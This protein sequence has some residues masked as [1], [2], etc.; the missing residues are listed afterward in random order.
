MLDGNQKLLTAFL[1]TLSIFKEEVNLDINITQVEI[2]LC[3]LAGD[4]LS[5]KQITEKF[6]VRIPSASR[7]V[8]ALTDFK[9]PGVPGY[10]LIELR[11]DPKDFRVKRLY[12]SK[13]GIALKNKLAANRATADAVFDFK[14]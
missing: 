4:G 5:I 9:R 12:L 8:R 1:K 3:L 10:G 14:T 6:G 2:Y 7:T 13:K 11:S